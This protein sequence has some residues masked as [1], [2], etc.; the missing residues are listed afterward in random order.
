MTRDRNT[1]TLHLVPRVGAHLQAEMLAA[2]AARSSISHQERIPTND[3]RYDQE[4]P[5]MRTVMDQARKNYRAIVY[6][7]LPAA[8]RLL[9]IVN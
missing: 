8:A 5:S 3:S 7:Q 6:G 4:W 9:E 2:A 1:I